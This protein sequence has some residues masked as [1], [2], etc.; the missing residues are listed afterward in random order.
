MVE[1][2]QGR[3]TG[4]VAAAVVA[5]GLI[6]SAYILRSLWTLDVNGL[7]HLNRKLPIWDFSNLWAG[8]LFARQGRVHLLFEVDA[9]RAA[10]RQL[11]TP[12][13]T[14]QEWSYPPSM[15]LLA[16]PLGL[17]PVVPAY[18]V[19]TF[20]TIGLLHLAIRPLKLPLLAHLAVLVSPSVVMN[21]VVGQNGAFT[22]S[23]LIAGLALAPRR[24]VVAGLLFGLL[25]MKPHLGLLV[26]FCLLASWNLR[27][28]LSAAVTTIL[29]AG[30]TTLF[31]GFDSWLLFRSVT[32]PLMTAILEAPYPQPYH[33][34]AFTVF[35]AARSFG[36]G[37]TGS[38]A[39]QLLFSALAVGTTVWLWLPG[40]RIGHGR[41]VVLTGLLALVVTPYGY[42]YDSVP[43]SIAV[44][45]LFA[46]ERRVP[47]IAHG[48]AWLYP[49]FVP[50]VTLLGFGA[51]IGVVLIY[52][53][54]NLLLDW[55]DQRI[56]A[57]PA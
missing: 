24:P 2:G 43:L 48:I 15:L 45:F 38:Y 14:D 25:T 20:G 26:P 33:T 3:L 40:T 50:V 41:R 18:L 9:Y 47:L 42:V 6:L 29:L 39:V 51:S 44:A 54:L 31:F 19:W 4:I 17:L 46:T 36:L 23:L 13:L 28:I 12:L 56:Q 5:F 10:L 53:A 7:S 11:F 49:L 8:G 57:I 21:A 16:V 27:A 30:I 52:L 32:A 37:L 55:R 22:A 34:L 35:A 1:N